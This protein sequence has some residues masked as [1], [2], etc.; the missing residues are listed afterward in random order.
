MAAQ[1]SEARLRGGL[2]RRV[3]VVLQSEAAECGLAC[4]AMIACWHGFDTDVA[5]LRRRFP[6]SLKGATL[7]RL[8]DV[9]GEMQLACRPLRLELHELQALRTPCILHWDLNHFVVLLRAGAREVRIIDPARGERVLPVAAVSRHFT[10]VALEVSPGA[11]FVR[12]RDRDALP[13]AALIGGLARARGGLLQ[14]VLLAIA[15]ETVVLVSP[16]FLQWVIDGAVGSA[17]VDLLLLLALGFGLLMVVQVAIASARSWAILYLGTRL[18]LDASA[19]VFAHLLRLPVGW[20]ESRHV[21]DIVSRFGSMATLQRTL[22]AGFVETL[23]DGLM[24]FATLALMLFYSVALSLVAAGSAVLYLLLRWAAFGPYR[25]ATEEQIVLASR[26]NSLFIESVRAVKAIKLF[27]HEEARL[28]AW[29]NANVDAAGRG[30]VGERHLILYRGAQT[31]LAGAEHIVIVFLGAFA[32]IEGGFSVGMLLAFLAYKTTFSTRI[33]ALIDKWTQLKMLGLHRD[34]LADIVLAAPEAAGS[35]DGAPARRDATLELD[36]VWFRYGEAEPW[37]LRDVSLRIEPGE[38][39]AIAGPS[40]C[41]KTTLLKILMGLLP[42]AR[43]EVRIGG[44]PLQALGARAFRRRVAA[45]LQDDQLL[46]GSVLQNI[47]FFDA[48]YD[49]A[50]VEACA[51]IAGVHDEIAAMPMGYETLVG[52]MGSCLSG[53][54]KQRVLL[55]RAL[56]KRP[57]ILFLDEATSHL[58]LRQEAVISESVKALRCTRVLV[59]HRPQSLATADRVVVLEQGEVRQDLRVSPEFAGSFPRAEAATR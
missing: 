6:V 10:G 11:A 36:G 30:L 50:R 13:L 4:L 42:V 9:A 49:R 34:R 2:S 20:F 43:G 25:A 17:D 54:Q 55:A 16:F 28:A 39:V 51:R 29:S 53:G 41:G 35:V 14:I 38:C 40:G 37:V 18:S 5:A 32:V 31:F 8:V 52:D 59:A 48:Q 58:D 45:V 1:S 12:G 33:A 44:V 15:L 27:N 3:P 26:A 21:G 57:E 46:A 47:G 23:I 19:G 22:T 7:Q 56:Y 24:A